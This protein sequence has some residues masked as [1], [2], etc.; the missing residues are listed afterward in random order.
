MFLTPDGGWR[1]KKGGQKRGLRNH[2]SRR[3]TARGSRTNIAACPRKE[4]RVVLGLS[5]QIP[6]KA[7]KQAAKL[8]AKQVLHFAAASF[9]LVRK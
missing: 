4:R 3:G 1:R 6:P 7:A 8:V 2:S 9:K 5:S